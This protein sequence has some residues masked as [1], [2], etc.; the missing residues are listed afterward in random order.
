[1]GATVFKEFVR[2]SI[3][4]KRDENARLAAYSLSVLAEICKNMD[5]KY[6][7]ACNGT[8]KIYRNVEAFNESIRLSELLAPLDIP[9][10]ELDAD[11]VVCQEPAL[12]GIR[13]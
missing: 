2:G 12:K 6:D 10:S 9:F 11:G 4:S 8:L 3:P 13:N 1:L 7:K 5:I